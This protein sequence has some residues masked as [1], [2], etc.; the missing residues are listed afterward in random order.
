MS[1]TDLKIHLKCNPISPIQLQQVGSMLTTSL[2]L[3]LDAYHHVPGCIIDDLSII[4]VWIYYKNIGTS[5][6]KVGE[7]KVKGQKVRGSLLQIFTFV[8]GEFL[9][10]LGLH[11]TE[12][13]HSLR[14]QMQQPENKYFFK[15][16]VILKNI[17]IETETYTFI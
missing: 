7:N 13:H 2:T 11:W 1:V 14:K 10:N 5:T 15:K 4:F 9:P 8:P 12:E 16:Y 3:V 6:K 17:Y